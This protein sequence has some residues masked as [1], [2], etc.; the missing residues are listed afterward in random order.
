[1]KYLIGVCVLALLVTAYVFNNSASIYTSNEF[2]KNHNPL[3]GAQTILADLNKKNLDFSLLNT[4]YS[5]DSMDTEIAGLIRTDDNGQLIVDTE[6][7]AFMDYFLSSVGQVTPQEALERLRLHFY[8]DLP[9]HAAEQAMEVLKNYLA[10]KEDSFDALARPIDAERSE[11]DANY[12]YDILDQ[13]LQTLYDLRRTHL[14]AQVA[15]ALFYED[16]AYAHYTLTKMKADLNEN[17][18]VEERQQLKAIAKAQLPEN[19]KEIIIRQEQQAHAMQAYSNLLADNPST[20]EVTAFAFEHFDSEQAQAIIEDYQ[21]QTT[22]KNKYNQFSQAIAQLN[23]Q[24]LDAASEQQA[25]K[26]MAAQYF[27]HEEYSMVQAWQLAKQGQP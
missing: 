10:F 19:M 22:L 15:E 5:Q 27:T 9:E 1:M 20:E 14:G 4:T 21:A 18:S 8:K 3:R 17:L 16:E 2:T 7:K 11:Y 26:D 12:R 13:G 24:G 6:F 25:I 23:N